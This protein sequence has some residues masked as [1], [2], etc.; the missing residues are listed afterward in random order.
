MS[1]KL[2]TRKRNFKDTPEPAAA[3]KK[4]KSKLIFVVQRHK[5]SRLHYDL[6]LELDGVLKSW[7]VPKGPS[8]DPKDKRLA[9]HV[10]DHPFDYA[11]FVGVIP[12]KHYGAGAVVVWDC[13]VWSPDE[14]REYWFHGR[15]DAE[16]RAL[17][18]LA[19]LKRSF[20]LC[21]EKNNGSFTQACSPDKKNWFLIKHKDRFVARTDVTEQNR[22]VLCGLTVA[23]LKTA[24]VRRRPASQLVP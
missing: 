6:R 23:D 14:D 1:L 19:Q 2:Y 12:P 21:D 20:T 18:G 16:R 3:S 22:S 17:A 9:V 15:A 4:T 5:A 24:P 10:E 7:A 11:S 13:G 8:L